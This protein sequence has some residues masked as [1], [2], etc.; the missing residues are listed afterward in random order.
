VL[1]KDMGIQ[2]FQPIDAYA[3]HYAYHV[4][5]ETCMQELFDV[6]GKRSSEEQKPIVK[7][8]VEAVNQLIKANKQFW[9][10]VEKRQNDIT[11]AMG[12]PA[13]GDRLNSLDM[14]ELDPSD[15][16]EEA[17]AQFLS[18]WFKLQKMSLQ[19]FKLQYAE[20]HNFIRAHVF[21]KS[22]YASQS[23]HQLDVIAGYRV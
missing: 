15:E 18:S 4:R 23:E 2:A 7:K 11:N 20:Q 16:S 9:V 13:W 1:L 6:Q 3:R 14:P 12:S 19:I 21:G 8:V 5:A 17:G 22:R 10:H